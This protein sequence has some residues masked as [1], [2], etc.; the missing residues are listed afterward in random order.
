MSSTH[1]E[2]RAQGIPVIVGIDH[3]VLTVR[4]LDA[5]CD[6]YARVLGFQR[7]DGNGPTSL[8]FGKHK[9][10]VHEVGRTFDPK[11]AQ[12]TPGA[13]DICFIADR[14]IEDVCIHLAAC[15]VQIELGPIG[16]MGGQGEM[17]SVYF[18]DPDH[19]LIEVARY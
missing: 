14:S 19:N 9:I 5:T 11:A 3:V 8:Q 10:S 16:R 17:I 18:R 4:S 13:I 15:G 7:R 1:P 6:F 12:P 2:V